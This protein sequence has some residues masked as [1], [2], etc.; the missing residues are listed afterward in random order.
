MQAYIGLRILEAQCSTAFDASLVPRAQQLLRNMLS[1]MWADNGDALSEMYTGSGAL[2]SGL[3]RTGRRGFSGLMDDARKTVNRF[4]V[5]T[6]LDASRQTTIDLL[7]GKANVNPPGPM[8]DV[9]EHLPTGTGYVGDQLTPLRFVRIT[10]GLCSSE[11]AQADHWEPAFVHVASFN[12]NG[13]V[14]SATESLKV[15]FLNEWKCLFFFY[16]YWTIKSDAV[17]MPDI[18]VIGFQ[19]MVPLTAQ[20]LLASD[21]SRRAFWEHRLL[22]LFNRSSKHTRDQPR[23]V[24]LRSTQLVGVALFIFVKAD[25]VKSYRNVFAA[26]IKV[27][28]HLALAQ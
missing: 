6:F 3:T 17:V 5:N 1:D 8:L 24:L 2:K 25:H 11:L 19:E 22:R 28:L 18:Y 27:W 10:D 16:Y 15:L 9:V 4:Y 21:D 12:L 14:P 26:S 13:Q 7:L 23:Y 20:H